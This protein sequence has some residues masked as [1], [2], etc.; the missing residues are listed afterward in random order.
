MDSSWSLGR[1]TF[2]PIAAHWRGHSHRMI[3]VDAHEDLAWNMITFGRDYTR[4]VGETRAL[5]A[6]TET[7]MRNGHTLL[8][9]AEWVKGRVG[10][11]FATLFA[12]PARHRKG[13]WDRLCY[14]EPSEANRLYLQQ[15]DLY[16]CLVEDHADKFLVIRNQPDL[17]S[18]LASW[19]EA[20]PSSPLIGLA[21]LMEGAEG[22]REPPE[23][24]DWA[25]RGVRILGPAWAGTRFCGGTQEPGPLTKEGYELLEAMAELGMALDLSHMAERAALQ[26]LERYPGAIIASHS[27]VLALV[28]NGEKPDRHLSDDVISGVIERGAVIGVV[29]YNR[30]LLGG[31]KP[32]DGRAMVTVEHIVAHIDRICQRAGSALNVG[33]GSDFDGGFGLDQ[34]PAGLDSVADLRLIGNALGIRGYSQADVEAILGGNWIRILRHTLPER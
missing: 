32:E 33:I 28:P 24:A 14:S 34:I 13:P 16:E 6:G 8:G 11:V 17:N 31:W 25:E 27:N 2:D 1:L 15:L 5:E 9:W 21:L 3:I 10:I 30:F 22:V 29:P 19:Q 20:Q 4:S 23:L 7:I 12:G 18:V 26:A